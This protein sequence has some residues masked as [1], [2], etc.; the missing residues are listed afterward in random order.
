M[1][2][3]ITCSLRPGPHRAKTDDLIVGPRRSSTGPIRALCPVSKD[4]REQ[5]LSADALQSASQ[6][7]SISER[8][9]WTEQSHVL[10]KNGL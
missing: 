3:F 9:L 1:Y 5:W 10:L 2:T 4:H 8:L 7:V 6:V